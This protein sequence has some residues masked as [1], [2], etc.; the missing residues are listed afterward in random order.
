ML[1][2]IHDSLYSQ[3]STYCNTEEQL[4]RCYPLANNAPDELRGS[5]PQHCNL[6]QVGIVDCGLFAIFTAFSLARGDDMHQKV[7]CRWLC[8]SICCD[9]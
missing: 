7:G 6:Q 1:L 5:T 8:D 4:T 9:T 3:F 2:E